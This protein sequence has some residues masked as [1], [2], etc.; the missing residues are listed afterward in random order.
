MHLEGSFI[1]SQLAAV[2]ACIA[3]N[4]ALGGGW[5]DTVNSGKLIVVD[6]QNGPRVGTR[7]TIVVAK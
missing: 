7:R 5:T 1:D 4:K 2:S 3:L 6:R